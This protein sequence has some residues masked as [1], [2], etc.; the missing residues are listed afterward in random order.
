MMGEFA[1]ARGD[2]LT[3]AVQLKAEFAKTAAEVDREGQWPEHNLKRIHEEGLGKFLLPLAWGGTAS[4]DGATSDL[5][6][7]A[8][9]ITEIS[10]GESSTAQIWSIH[11][12]VTRLIFGGLLD[13]ADSVKQ[14]LA[15]EVLEEGARIANSV[16]EGGK[17]RRAFKTTATRKG[18]DFVVSGVKLFCTGN[19][20]AR[21]TIASVMSDA[22]P[23]NGMAYILIPTNTPGLRPHHDWDNM[24][25]RATASGTITFEDVVVPGRFHFPI[26][27]GPG[28]FSSPTS[29]FGLFFQTAINAS[30]LG[31]G[32]GA[33][34]AMCEHVRKFAR[35][36]MP[37]IDEAVEDPLNRWHV[38]R[39][40]A[41]LWAARAIQR[42]SACR[43][44]GVE[45]TGN[46]RA[47]ASVHMMR[48]K[49]AIIE[50]VLEASGQLHRLAGGRATHNKYRLDRFWRNAR[51]LTVHD[52]VDTKL[53][54]IGEYELEGVAPPPSMTS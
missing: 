39:L 31:M 34:D 13:V 18:D 25:Q 47:E 19:E 37:T 11:A 30:I 48:S 4:D 29:V 27:G 40:S 54:Q 24:G 53:Q 6:L 50:A 2:V 20:G 38:G 15:H 45:R 7:L 28:A 42:E 44:W 21:Y 36:N 52:S 51:T 22:V 14:Q 35:P 26:K 8:E 17:Q 49:F 43:I 10:A 5:D 9:V 33:L 23:D 41:A 32:F 3:R 16:A 46:N 12:V 1:G